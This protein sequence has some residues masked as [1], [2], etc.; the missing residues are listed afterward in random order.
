MFEYDTI[1]LTRYAKNSKTSEARFRQIIKFFALD[2]EASKIATITGRSRNAINAILNL[3]R[4]IWY[5]KL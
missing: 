1:M 2:L 4:R 3:Y 5:G